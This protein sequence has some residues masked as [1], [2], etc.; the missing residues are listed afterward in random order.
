VKPDFDIIVIGGGH[1]GAE[2]SWAAAN[3]GARVALV[4]LDPSTIG[5]MSCNPAIGGLAKGQIVREIDAMGGLMGLAADA[6]GILF[7][8]LNTSRGPAVWGPRCQCDKHAYARFIR[9]ALGSRDGIE[10]VAGACARFIVENDRVLGI[11]CERDGERFGL[12]AG[13]VVLTTGTFMRGLLHTGE[14]TTPGGR[15]G[16][17]PA[18]A[19]SG[20]LREL[21][22]ELHRLKTGT[23]PRLDRGS[24]RWDELE[25]QL[26]DETPT[27]FSDLTDRA[28]FPMIG[29]VDCR[30]THTNA[31]IH[32]VIRANLHRAPIF[33]GAIGSRGPRYCPSIEDK[34]VRF[35]DR[36][37]HHV[38][39]EPES[40][41]DDSVYCNGISTSLP[42]DV[43]DRIV[44]AMPGC[45]GAAILRYG[46]AVEYDAVRSHQ[47]DATC[48]T[49][50]VRGLFL[51]GQINGTTGYEEAAGQGL[52]AGMNAVRLVRGLERR[53]LTRDEAYLGV[54]MD[55]LVTKPL[56]EPYRMFTSRAEHRLI[57]RADNSAD[58]LTP[59]ADEL[60]LLCDDRREAFAGRRDALRS[61]ESMIDPALGRAIVQPS[62]MHDDMAA[63]FPGFDAGVRLTAMAERQYAG[64][65]ARQRAE[66]K[67]QREHERRAIPERFDFALVDGLR[68]EARERL[69]RHRP[70]SLG[71]AGRLEGVNPTDV[72]LLTIAMRRWKREE[73]ETAGDP[74]HYSG[75]AE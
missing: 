72:T 25:A 55:D 64:Y 40:H 15:S 43:Q 70:A 17:P 60:G 18:N 38:F 29:Q 34:V 48:M 6:T 58:R 14:A 56:T 69:T 36:Q 13:A 45:E 47:I 65:I 28:A 71:Q 23:P 20:A 11:E 66:I 54:M 62:F 59:I 63:A 53:A 24:I 68:A 52:I 39:L 10:V 16:E 26:G 8:T 41:E 46:Y 50:R 57:L 9:A 21:G 30:I 44:G 31:A 22:F 2:A 5:V 32:D 67:R 73:R 61:I 37:S 49:R 12:R 19:I 3:S 4:T 35:A 42:E 74:C 27:P 7:K 75:F 33:N 1:A 51:A